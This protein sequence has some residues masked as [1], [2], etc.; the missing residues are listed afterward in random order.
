VSV[1]RRPAGGCARTPGLGMGVLRVRDVEL[2]NGPSGDWPD[3]LDERHTVEVVTTS[4]SPASVDFRIRPE[5]VEIWFQE[6]RR[7]VLDRHV[8]R[9]WLAEPQTPL[10]VDEV[11]FSLDR[12]ADS[13]ARVALSLP[14]VLV[15]T[16]SPDVLAG[17]RYRI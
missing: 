6:R 11:A 14:D 7:A 13:P 8:L 1:S 3:D 15:W 10:V 12:V 2:V 9:C 17:L 16:L 5:N 4:G